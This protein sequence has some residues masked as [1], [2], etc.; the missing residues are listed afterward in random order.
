M[1]DTKFYKLLNLIQKGDKDNILS[2]AKEH[3]YL[4]KEVAKYQDEYGYYTPV[5][6]LVIDG[7]SD[8]A[9]ELAKLNPKVLENSCGFHKNYTPI[10]SLVD[11]TYINK[12]LEL[13][14]LN[15]KSLL[16]KCGYY[17]KN[18]MD[19]LIK[20]EDIDLALKFGKINTKTIS[21]NIIKDLIEKEDI[22]DEQILSFAKLNPVE[23]DKGSDNPMMHAIN[24]GKTDLADK[25]ID[26]LDEYNAPQTEHPDL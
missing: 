19:F 13:A 18:V 11:K 6:M 15:P 5:C 10:C 2:Y 4:I 16:K 14:K 17:S 26:I 22:K 3:S 9:F 23:L 24:L 8:I 25:L 12:A 7:K 21:A 20:R 1:T